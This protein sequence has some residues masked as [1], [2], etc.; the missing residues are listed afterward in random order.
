LVITP[1]VT[2]TAV[3]LVTTPVTSMKERRYDLNE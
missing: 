1:V 2:T 3:P